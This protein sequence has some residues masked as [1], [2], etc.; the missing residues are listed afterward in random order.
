VYTVAIKL[1]QNGE[2][3]SSLNRQRGLLF[4]LF[5]MMR[6]Y[7]YKCTTLWKPHFTHR[8]FIND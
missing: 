7:C 4:T 6:R 5:M 3:T 1:S 8:V 2:S